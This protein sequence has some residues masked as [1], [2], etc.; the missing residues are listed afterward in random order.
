MANL[1]RIATVTVLAV[2]LTAGSVSLASA[3]SLPLPTSSKSLVI[4]SEPG[5]FVGQGLHYSF[6]G[7]DA[8]FEAFQ[9]FA[10]QV[11]FRVLPREG[12]FW[13]LHFTAPIGQ[14]LV[15]GTYLGALRSNTFTPEVAAI[16]IGGNGRGCNAGYGSFVL[17]EIT[18]AG[19]FG[20]LISFDASFEYH[21]ERVD[22]PA[23][24][25]HIRYSVDSTLPILTP[26]IAPA[27]NASGWN[28]TNVVVSWSV[29]DPESGIAWSDCPTTT[30]SHET[31]AHGVFCRAQNGDGRISFASVA[32]RIDKTGP[33]ISAARTPAANAAGWN[34]GDVI[35]S[36]ACSDTL[37]GVVSCQGSQ[38][39]Q[40][41]G[42]GQ[43]VTGTS[44]DLAGNSTSTTVGG[45][46]IDRTAPA[47]TI[48]G[49]AGTYTVDQTILITCQASD[50]LS[51]IAS[52][53]CPE[54]A[55]GPATNYVGT[56]AT[57]ITTRTTTASDTAGNST[58]ASTVFS[59]TV[60]ADGICRLTASLATADDI[61]G[62]AT[63]IATAPNATSKVGKLQAFDNFLA[64]QVGKSIPSDLADVLGRLARML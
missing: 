39:L 19:N 26:T 55:S 62:K 7:A 44:T 49:N 40:N 63:S 41:E 10:T 38:I 29:S 43:S 4:D 17:N 51:G 53:T 34:N 8:T 9:S 31:F 50:A 58:S 24:R 14:R 28:A 42:A 54:V 3:D 32:V 33:S 5:D 11:H 18:T 61:C 52:T 45:I 1:Q 23:L 64:A 12:G 46:N 59:V 60:T 57:T 2:S 6:S 35:V 22:A 13:I 30:V 48:S 37:S 21:C 36:I 56:S 27:P 47:I 15:P 20:D 25:G 16:D